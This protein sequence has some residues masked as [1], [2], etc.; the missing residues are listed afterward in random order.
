MNIRYE[1]PQDT[2]RSE[3]MQKYSVSYSGGV[4]KNPSA[5]PVRE[6]RT[7]MNIRSE[8]PQDTLRSGCIEKYSDSNSGEFSDTFCRPSQGGQNVDRYKV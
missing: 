4:F 3:S 5:G 1:R 2:L 7:S 8:R 6:A